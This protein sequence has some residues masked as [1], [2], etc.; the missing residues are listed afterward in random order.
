MEYKIALLL[1]EHYYRQKDETFLSN[2][3]D[4]ELQSFSYN[5][6]DELNDIFRSIKDKFDGFLVSGLIP[7]QSLLVSGAANEDDLIVNCPIDIEN[8]YRILL[9]QMTVTKNLQLSRIGMDFLK[10]GHTL[11]DLIRNDQFAERVHSHENRW[12]RATIQEELIEEENTV[13]ER[14]VKLYKEGRIDVII[15]YFYSAVERMKKYDIDCYYVYPSK[16]MF[17]QLVE[18]LKKSISLRALKDRFS[19]VIHIDM[20]EMHKLDNFA[21]ERYE[22]ELNR[23]VMEFN[24]Q[25]LNQLILKKN[26]NN[27]ELYTDC[28]VLKELTGDFKEC[29]MWKKLH[30][31]LGFN[32]SIGYGIG[33]GIYQARTK[34][35][36]ACHYGRNGGAGGGSFLID[37]NG[38]LTVLDVNGGSNTLKLP[39]E[40]INGISNKVKLSSETIVRIIGIMNLLKTDEITSQDLV[41]HLNLSLRSANKFLSNLEQKGLAQIVSQKRNGNKGRPV[42][43]YRI[44]L[45][46]ENSGK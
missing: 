31:E 11:E 32:G 20:E 43:V 36:D 44:L 22:W 21:Y 3:E 42:N 7:K 13:S 4:V 39:E 37:E 1:K 12:E 23:I 46:Y 6:L 15:T 10:D 26:Y 19:A 25:N 9:K 35:I 8:T 17:I 34:A 18:E 5:T 29:P 16:G 30:E 40:Y 41:T 24:Q 14:Y 28:C 45:E 2:F 27:W 33:T 38:T